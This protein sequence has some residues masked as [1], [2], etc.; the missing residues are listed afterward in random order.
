MTTDTWVA[1]DFETA[2]SARVSACSLGVAVIEDGEL[3]TTAS[4]LMRPPGNRYDQR[5]IAVHGITPAQTLLA[6]SYAEL[7]GEI[8][9]FLAGGRVL[10][11]SASFDI[12]VLRALHDH[13]RLPVPNA[14]YA[15]SVAMAR[16][17]FPHLANHKLP[18]VC[19]HCGIELH[20]HDAASDAVACARIALNCREAV[21]AMS[22]AEAIGELGVRVR[23]L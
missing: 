6:P 3:A 12:S 5:N 15:C 19:R 22:V 1:I 4:W 18:T 7:Y 21:G 23:R 8:E 10:A 14:E 11:H 17:A 13:Y 16:R 20:H 9:P 2:T